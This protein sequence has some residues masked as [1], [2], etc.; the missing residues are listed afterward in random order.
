MSHPV[1]VGFLRLL[2]EHASLTAQEAMDALDNGPATLRGY[3]YQLWVLCQY[4]LVEPNGNLT[5]GGLPYCL[6]NRGHFM[7]EVLSQQGGSA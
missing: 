5:E 7:L 6:T 4:G 1:R 2:G 3:N